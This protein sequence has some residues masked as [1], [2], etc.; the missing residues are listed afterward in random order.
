[1]AGEDLLRTAGTVRKRLGRWL[2]E[3][4][5]GW[6]K[7]PKSASDV[8]RLGA[9]GG[10]VPVA[11]AVIRS[12]RRPRQDD[13]MLVVHGT[14]KFLDRVGS[15]TSAPDDVSTTQLGSWYATVLFWKSRVA[16]FVSEETLLPMLLPLA[17]AASVLDRFGGGLE[18]LLYAH[19]V[20]APFIA[21][22]LSEVGQCRLAKTNNRSVLGSMNEFA[23]LA[24]AFRQSTEAFDLLAL[25]LRL[26]E[27]PC[28][29]LYKSHVTPHDELL[30]R[31]AR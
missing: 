21:A 6:L 25:S 1:M 28:S 31:A 4:G 27:T 17:P 7:V 3:R 15:S 26:A 24:D 12:A 11:R 23:Y 13:P 22:E 2:E 10:R 29:P 18:T 30:A 5:I 20:A 19:G 9:G 16:L 14:K 8:A